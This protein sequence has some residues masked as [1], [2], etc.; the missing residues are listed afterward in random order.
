MVPLNTMSA[1]AHDIVNKLLESESVEDRLKQIA[2]GIRHCGD[3]GTL[4]Y[5]P[6]KHE[7]HWNAADSD[8]GGGDEGFTPLK[9]IEKMLK[10]PG[11]RHVE[12]GDEWSPDEDDG[13]V[14]L[15]YEDLH[16]AEEPSPEHYINKL[17]P[18]FDAD[19]AL[20]R[21]QIECSYCMDN[22]SDKEAFLAWIET[23]HSL[24]P[25]V[26]KAMEIIGSNDSWCTDSE[27]DMIAFF[28]AL[29]FPI[30]GADG[31]F[32]T[33]CEC[34]NTHQHNDTVCRWCYARGRRHFNDPAV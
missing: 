3:Y 7:V 22:P 8:G 1:T 20:Q 12:I 4:F 24:F 31:H 26:A 15:H 34:D 23:N 18:A 5:H 13:W 19:T 10:L 33:H 11:I 14:R 6:G 2:K 29:G 16:E 30:D 25:D 9:E 27:D 17:P 32:L 28:E 21:I